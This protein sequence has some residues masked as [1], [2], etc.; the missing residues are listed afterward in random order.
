MRSIIGHRYIFNRLFIQYVRPHLEFAAPAWFPWTLADEEMLE[1]V[2]RR[3]IGMISGLN[4]LGHQERFE[5]LA[6][7]AS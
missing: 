7:R 1:K 5:E 2:Q 3:A 4:G 6:S